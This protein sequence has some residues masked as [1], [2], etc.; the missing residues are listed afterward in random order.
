[1]PTKLLCVLLLC[2]AI[3]GCGGGGSG[4]TANTGASAPTSAT[5][6]ASAPVGASTPIKVPVQ[7][8]TVPN[9][10]PVT[11]S[12][13]PGLT[14][15]MLM[16]SVTLCEPGTDH[17]ATID[18]VQVDTGSQ[19]LRVLASALPAGLALPA[20][21]STNG[22]VGQ[23]AVFGTGYTWGAVRSADVRMAG[24][25][26]AALPIHIIADA[27]V[28]TVPADCGR[29]GLAMMSTGALRANGILGV[30]LFAADCGG[31]CA[32][33]PLPR[34]YY[35]CVP[36]GTCTSSTQ[37]VASQVTNPVSRFAFDNNG[38]VIDLPAVPDTGSPSVSGSLIFGIGTQ[39]NNVPDGAT[40]LKANTGTGYITTTVDGKVYTQSFFD[41]GSNGLFFASTTLSVCGLWYCPTSLQTSTATIKGTDGATNILSFPVGN[42]Q[43]LF[44]TS[45]YAFNNL[46]G[47]AGNVFDWGL[48]FFFGRKVFTAID[49]RPTPGGPGP[50][51][52]F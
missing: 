47:T 44:A 19:G 38:V 2:A 32:N 34:W 3:T 16:T 35:D 12:A 28:P 36:G 1:M 26:A 46:A 45:N 52:A 9:V 8:S 31:A 49:S 41:S 14:R 40:V 24:E 42:A 29:S 23:C 18:N 51:Y 11:V 20:I 4:E 10:Q 25:I 27:S 50:Y 21:P 37:P 43:M 30:G 22:T 15:N 5:P 33:S 13:T 7:Q 39:A 48:P 17:C 6:P